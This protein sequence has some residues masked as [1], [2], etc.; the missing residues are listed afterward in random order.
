MDRR[1]LAVHRTIMVVDIEQFGDRRRTNPHRVAVRAGL[2]AALQ[3]AFDHAQ[4]PWSALDCQD[5]GDGIFILAPAHV[6]KAL[7]VDVVPQFV[8]IALR[9]HNATRTAEERIRLRMALHAGEV[10]YDEHGVTAT[11]VNVAFRLLEAPQLKTM[12]ADSPGVLA[13]ITSGWFYDE[14]VRH[15]Q[16]I[17]PAT[18]RPIWVAVKETSMTGWISRPDHPYPPTAQ[19]LAASP[20]SKTVGLVPH[21]LPAAPRSFTGRGKELSVLTAALETTAEAG[22][23]A[24]ISTIGGTGGI[25][26]TWL[27]LTWAYRELHQFPDG[28]LFADLHG[29]SPSGQPAHPVDVLG[30]FLDALGIDRGR[31]P[32][33]PDRRA[34]LYRSLVADKRMLIVL[35]NA[36]TTDQVTPL[37]P[38]GPHCTV[39]ITSRNHLHGLMVHHGAH[40]VHLDVLTHTEAHTLLTTALD[41][42]P[43]S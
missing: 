32:T 20:P 18:F 13:L 22:Q 14:V 23:T 8:A 19:T 7:F 10:T 3:K 34:D 42:R 26:K 40:P 16:S 15:S 2:Y 17:D 29:F 28:Q 36:A 33:H 4:V 35:D 27:A 25:G 9:E 38:G 31:Q 21:Q 12:L 30:G 24:V 43:C 39:L 5:C 37:L 11:A 41:P 6:P 1:Q